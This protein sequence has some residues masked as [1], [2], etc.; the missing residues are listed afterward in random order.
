MADEELEQ[1]MDVEVEIPDSE[2][3]D[4]DQTE[5]VEASSQT[6]DNF[7][8][9]ENS[10]QKRINRLTR[11]MRDAERNEQEALA[12]AKKVQEEADNLKTRLSA[13]DQGYLNESTARVTSELQSA[14]RDLKAA[15]EIGDTEAA[16]EAQK[17]ITHLAIQSDRVN[18]AKSQ[19]AQWEQQQQALR[20]QQAQQQ[21][22]RPQAPQID[23]KAQTWAQK[24]DWFGSDE[25]MTY[26]AFGIHKKLVEEEGFDPSS[27]DYYNELDERMVKEFPH[28]LAKN[29]GSKRPAQTVASVSR[30]NSGRSSGKKV[31]LSSRQVAMAKKLGVPVEEYAKYVKEG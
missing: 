9:A 6:E 22:A 17:R 26:A 19:Q 23:P 10:V 24:N 4:Q 29:G 25:A 28:K 27:D 21:Q 7:D 15:M 3:Q 2:D 13:M 11:K 5:E 12:Y 1:E 18:Q 8:K 20:E 30:G 16:V 31:R 14:E